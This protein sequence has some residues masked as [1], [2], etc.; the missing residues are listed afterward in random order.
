MCGGGGE[1]Q[2]LTHNRQKRKKHVTVQ[3][4]SEQEPTFDCLLRTVRAGNC[5]SILHALSLITAALLTRLQQRKCSEKLPI[6]C[7][8]TAILRENHNKDRIWVHCELDWHFKDACLRSVCYFSSDDC[9][10]TKRLLSLYTMLGAF[11][12]GSRRSQNGLPRRPNRGPDL[13]SEDAASRDEYRTR[14]GSGITTAFTFE[15]LVRSLLPL[16][17]FPAQKSAHTSHGSSL[18]VSRHKFSA[19][20]L[21]T[22]CAACLGKECW[23]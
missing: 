9:C 18:F 22:S 13:S 6:V 23:R 15:T 3:Q 16:F 20:P 1:S 8:L 7:V 17:S 12:P 5:L 21:T 4:L 19:R 10:S 14:I 2:V 11:T